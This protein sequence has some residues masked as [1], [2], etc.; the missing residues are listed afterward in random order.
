MIS[1]NIWYDEPRWSSPEKARPA[2]SAG[3]WGWRWSWRTTL[4]PAPTA[5]TH[6]GGR[7]GGTD[8]RWDDTWNMEQL[9]KAACVSINVACTVGCISSRCDKYTDS[10]CMIHMRSTFAICKD[11]KIE[12][13][14][15]RACVVWLYNLLYCEIIMPLEEYFSVK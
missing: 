2:A 8:L 12:M 3:G 15:H 13:S 10:W 9:S 5:G 1:L 11:I 7:K 14:E 4:A 6:H